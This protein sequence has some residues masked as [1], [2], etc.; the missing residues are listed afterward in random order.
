VIILTADA[1]M[2]FRP[3][4]VFVVPLTTTPRTFPSHIPLEPDHLNGLLEPSC[5]LVEQL[6][7]IAIERCGKTLGNVGPI[8]THQILDVPRHDDRHAL[9]ADKNRS[10]QETGEQMRLDCLFR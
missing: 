9:S 1:F 5:A 10:N 8:A 2:R 4:T 3:A 7:A 6:R